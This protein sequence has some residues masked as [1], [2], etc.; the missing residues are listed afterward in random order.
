MA[1]D[2]FTNQADADAYFTNERFVT[3]L[4]DAANPANKEKAVT[5]GY[6]RMFYD[7][8]YNLPTLANATA[9]ELVPLRKATGEMAYYILQHLDDEDRRK[10]IQAQGTIE[11]GI[12]KEKYWEDMLT[13]LPIPPFVAALL[14]Q[15]KDTQ[16][17]RKTNI[18]RDEN[19]S[20]D[21]NVTQF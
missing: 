11:A 3:D 12:V 13:T 15:F 16:V 4:W 10:G 19:E 5:N 20:V 17:V 14:W 2:Y 18:D 7:P 9:D 6:N 1:W 8:D 21:E